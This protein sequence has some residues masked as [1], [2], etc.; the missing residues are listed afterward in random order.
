MPR[1]KQIDPLLEEVNSG[2]PWSELALSDL[3]WCIKHKQPTAEIASFLCPSPQEVIDKAKDLGF[4]L[5]RVIGRRPKKR[6]QEAEG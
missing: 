4:K 3:R 5:H 6:R 2:E 1:A